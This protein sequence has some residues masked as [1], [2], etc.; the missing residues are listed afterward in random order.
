[1]KY[2]ETK[3]YKFLYWWTIICIILIPIIIIGSQLV[4]K[5]F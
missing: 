1:M 5:I 3:T 4:R 2:Y